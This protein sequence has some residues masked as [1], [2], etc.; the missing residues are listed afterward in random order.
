MSILPP[1]CHFLLSWFSSK[2]GSM[3]VIYMM[4]LQF[5]ASASLSSRAQIDRFFPKM[6]KKCTGRL[7]SQ[8][9]VLCYIC[10][11]NHSKELFTLSKNRGEREKKITTVHWKTLA[12]TQDKQGQEQIESDL[13]FENYIEKFQVSM[14]Q[15]ISP[16]FIWEK[17]LTFPLQNM[18]CLFIYSFTRFSKVKLNSFLPPS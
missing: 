6:V 1:W 12:E 7:F 3:G 18:E 14:A 16:V 15:Y 9:R 2:S 4:S 8:R 10:L 11:C 13:T 5:T 17:V